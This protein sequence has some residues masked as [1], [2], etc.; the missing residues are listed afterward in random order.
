[1]TAN[2]WRRKMK[3]D[4]ALDVVYE[5]DD[6]PSLGK[7]LRLA[8]HIIFCRTCASHLERYEEARSFLQ[9]GFFPLS[10]DFSDLIMSRIYDESF[11]EETDEQLVGTGGFSVKG[12]IISGIA[13]L[14]SLTMV[15]FDQDFINI[16][17]DQGS[18]FLL[19]M[20][21]LTGIVITGYGALF[22]GS[23]LKEFS[24]RFKL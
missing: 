2:N 24:D 21:I 23:H 15:F 3:C 11:D 9:T 14:L 10:P 19:P 6:I 16:A 8:F 4:N 5:D 17:R 13:L 20:G 22:I 18:S 1:M 12:W 7:R